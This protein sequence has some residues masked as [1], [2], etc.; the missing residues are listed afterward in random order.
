[1]TVPS[2]IANPS[3]A[4]EGVRRIEWAAREMPVLRLIR[5][6]F[7]REKPLQRHPH[8]CLP[9]RHHR[10]GQPRHHPARRRRRPPCLREQPALDAGRCRGGAGQ[11][12]RHPGLRHLRRGQRDLLQA[13]PPG[14]RTQATADHGRRRRRRRRSCTR[15]AATCSRACVGGTEETTTGVIRLRAMAADGALGYPIVAINEADTKHLFD[16]R[17]GTGQS[18]LDGIIR[19][20]NVLLA[21]KVVR[22]RRLRLV[23]P[24]RRAPG[25]RHGRPGHRHRSRPGE[26]ARSSHGRLPRDADGARPPQSATSSSRSPATATSSTA[27]TSKR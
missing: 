19:A 1:M 18:T 13:H 2:D 23:R 8:D 6:R 21:G 27:R 17:Y 3:L 10:D 24:R 4:P 25:T 11:R 12:V 15:T 14:A 20:T 7:L 9:A 16:N 26:G 5:E 22:R